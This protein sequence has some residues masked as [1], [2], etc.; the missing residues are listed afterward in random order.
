M[1][2]AMSIRSSATCSRS[3]IGLVRDAKRKEVAAKAQLNAEERVIDALVGANAALST[4]D[5]FRKKLRANELDDKEIEIQVADTPAMP[6]FEIPGMPGS[7]VGMINLS[8]CSAR[9]SASAPRRARVTVQGQL[10]D[11]D[12]R[13]VRQADRQRSRSC[14]R[15]STT[16]RTT[17]SCFS[18]R[19]TRSAPAP[20]AI[21]ADVSA[22]RRAARSPAAD[23]GHHRRHQIRAGQDRPHP[24][25]RLRRVPH[26]QAVRPACPSCRGGCRSA[27][28]S[29]R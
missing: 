6:A 12:G 20:S 18:T 2:A 14:R 19:S 9:R 26:R 10:R 4:R 3:G 8:T 22:R 16:S 24:V 28:S 25:H 29:A 11:A 15:R 5:A 7:Q 21:G 13:G 23:R 17:A 27:S 1:S